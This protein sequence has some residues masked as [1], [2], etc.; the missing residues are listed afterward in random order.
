MQ[1]IGLI[2]GMSW[3]SSAAYYE[4]LNK[5]VQ[6]RLGGLHSAK[7]VLASVD[8]AE[9]TAC[10]QSG[11]WDRAGAILSEAAQGLE[12]AGADFILLCATTFHQVY[13][14]V[15]A[16]VSVPVIHLADVLAEKCKALGITTVGFLSTAYTM[17]NEFFAQRISDHGLDVNLP[18][19]LHIETIDSIIYNELVF[20]TVEPGSRRRIATIVDE[21]WDSGA[22]GVI[23]GASE[24]SLLVRP[25]DVEVPVLDVI[26]VHVEAALER[27]FADAE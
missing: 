6:A 2:G 10:Q 17:E 16:A 14:T 24:L 19:S 11:D 21:L 8:F 27:A 13:D 18:D 5:G 4:G 3:E 23:L 12:K 7:T 26:T 9:V 20:R 1:T 25:E 15:A 22:Q